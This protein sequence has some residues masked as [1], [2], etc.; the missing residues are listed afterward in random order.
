MIKRLVCLFL[1]GALLIVSFV[2]TA[3]TGTEHEQDLEKVLLGSTLAQYTKDPNIRKLFGY[4]EDAIYLCIDQAGSDGQEWLDE[5]NNDFKVEGLPKSINEISVP[6]RSPSGASHQ[7][8]THLG[9][10][11]EDYKLKEQWEKRQTILLATVTKVFGFSIDE[12]KKGN[13]RFSDQCIEISK[14]IYYIHILGDHRKDSFDTT[15]DRLALANAKV[16]K[17]DYTTGLVN[18]LRSCIQKLFWSQRTSYRYNWLM[19]KLNVIRFRSWTTGEEDSES[20]HQKV[21]NIA[22]D[23]LNCLQPQI[24]SLLLEMDFFK[25]V[26][27]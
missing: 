7:V 13:D 12:S 5:L 8:Y 24:R 25:A 10:D 14:L 19:V 1:C 23:A 18:E 6:K 15:A 9:W 2:C 22:E 4:L 11:Y 17:G 16:T 26:F 20:K 3:A 21:Q 27:G